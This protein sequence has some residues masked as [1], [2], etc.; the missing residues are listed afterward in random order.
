M[1]SNV[2]LA[3]ALLD[4][5]DNTDLLKKYSTSSP[6]EKV[7]AMETLFTALSMVLGKN[8]GI[9]IVSEVG[10]KRSSIEEVIIHVMENVNRITL[11]AAGQSTDEF[12]KEIERLNTH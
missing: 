3:N 8:I 7:A 6:E 4:T 9:H 2:E 10:S 12:F 5:I 11:E 1:I